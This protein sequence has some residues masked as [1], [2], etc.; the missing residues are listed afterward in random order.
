MVN[1]SYHVYL[2]TAKSQNQL[3]KWYFKFFYNIRYINIDSTRRE[4]R[5]FKIIFKWIRQKRI[6]LFWLSHL[7]ILFSFFVFRL[8][9]DFRMEI[10]YKWKCKCTY[11]WNDW[12]WWAS[13][14]MT[15]ARAIENRTKIYLS[16]IDLK[17]RFLLAFCLCFCVAQNIYVNA[18]L[19]FHLKAPHFT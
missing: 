8:Y 1:L 15:R 5:F 7:S 10:K 14:R 11:A 19:C 18:F 16:I 2:L 9:F 4:E 6:C 17:P 3:P 12:V 13:V